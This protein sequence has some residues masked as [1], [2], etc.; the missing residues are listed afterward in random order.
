MINQLEMRS[1]P[2]GSNQK[3]KVLEK[4]ANW[5][6]IVTGWMLLSMMGVL[7]L[8]AQSPC[9]QDTAFHIVVLGSS[10]AAG[11]GSSTADSA[12]VNRY[13][14]HLQAINPANQVTNRAQG[15]FVTYRLMPTGFTPPSNRPDPDTTRNITYAIGL[16]PDAI[17]VNLPSNDVSL[18]YS[19]AEQLVNFDTMV[20]HATAANIPIWVC[21][22]Q[23][24]NYGNN[25]IPIQKK[26]DVR[27]SIWAKFS[28]RVL[29][30][31]TGL[32]SPS[33]QLSP[34]Y[35]SGDGTHLNDA[36]H[37][38][39]FSRANAED[40]PGQLF[41]PVNY[42]DH[43]AGHT[44][45]VFTPECGDSM[46]LFRFALHNRGL[47]DLTDLPVE[48]IVE[49]IGGPTVT[50]NDTL[51][52]GL[53][54]CAEDSLDFTANTFA[55]GD[56]L[57]TTILH[58]PNDGN[59][60]NDTSTLMMSFL[61]HPTLTP[62]PDTG[63]SMMPLTIGATTG[64]DDSLRWF[65]APTGGNLLAWG[66][67]YTTPPLSASTTY[68]VEAVRGDFVFRNSLMTTNT[69]N[70]NWNGTMFDIVADSN[71]VI[72]SLA[73]KVNSTGS[74]AVMVYTQSGSYT[75]FE[76]NAAAW[77]LV[78]TF[79]VQVNDP[80]TPVVF[81]PPAIAMSAGDTLGVYLHMQNS[82]SNLSYQS[83]GQPL[84]RSNNEI[85]IITG[86]G[87]AYNFSGTFF[88]RD[89]NGTVYYHFGNRPD[90]DCVSERIAVEAAIGGVAVD[91]GA[92]TIVNTSASIV[93]DPGSGFSSYLWSDGS[94]GQTL[95]LDGSVLGTGI[96]T[97]TVQVTDALGC[98]DM[99]TIIVVFAPLLGVEAP[100]DRLEV[101]PN[102]TKDAFRLAVPAG[103]WRLEVRDLTGRMVYREDLSCGGGCESS[104]A[105]KGPA[106]MYVVE[107][108]NAEQVLRT[109][110][111]KTD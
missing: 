25:P 108:K 104:V 24:K 107:L 90:G 51:F 6:K 60:L 81:A 36:G 72:D 109:R 11:A 95:T 2:S 84:S 12:W 22:T 73:L 23:P 101:W 30:F 99:D 91:L 41:V 48:F 15:G 79:P 29:D 3:E 57:L 16:N 58:A 49:Q 92:D 68:Y 18:G 75:G 56:Y 97:V 20:A 8:Q 59:A 33:N 5:T 102:P 27:D 55:G 71:L 44:W 53:S 93:L 54:T 80:N 63:C 62:L 83:M 100:V 32:N 85:E 10:T 61:G 76:G 1:A 9:L 37:G 34:T 13:R 66:D 78:G 43:V 19:V 21:T 35:D 111:M 98:M 45:P 103:E 7:G 82:G 52:G 50:Y 86:S 64:Q 96:Y 40:I 105:L 42:I 17:I 106:G 87:I 65:D 28:P 88:P 26:I 70:I 89:W 67:T 38:L 47:D 46:S 74:Q 31:W 110:L 4:M 94:T 39:L 14:N 77:T 69:S